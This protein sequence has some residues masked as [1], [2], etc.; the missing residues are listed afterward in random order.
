MD[1]IVGKV[2]YPGTG[3]PDGPWRELQGRRG[4]S[5]S[6]VTTRRVGDGLVL[7]DSESGR[8]FALDEI[9]TRAWSLLISAPSFQAAYDRLLDEFDVDPGVLHREMG[10]LVARL[11]ADG[12]LEIAR[13]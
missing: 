6:R 1:R 10:T 7:L 9:G 4:I 13:V 5:P 2:G 8:Y 11:V 3:E 12:L